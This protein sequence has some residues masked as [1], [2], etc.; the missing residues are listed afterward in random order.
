MA[1][2]LVINA[3]SVFNR[4]LLRCGNVR[5][6]RIVLPLT[7]LLS[8]LASTFPLS[9]IASGPMCTLA[10][11]AGRPPHPAGSCM[12][13]SF[14][15]NLRTHPKTT[16]I[17]GQQTTQEAEQVCG[18]PQRTSRANQSPLRILTSASSVAYSERSGGRHSPDVSATTV[19]K[20]CQPECGSSASSFSSSNRQRN[21]A[22][23]AHA[24][25]PRPPSNIRLANIAYS[26]IRKLS[27]LCRQCAPR[28]PPVSFS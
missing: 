6:A 22:A 24:V 23:I 20:P 12:N 8:L 18:L 4:C 19:A 21:T 2:K 1:S 10:C 5:I 9:T 26:L 13:G 11:C 3:Q 28:A 15:A 27:A 25:R 17:H 16:H 14:H 7:L